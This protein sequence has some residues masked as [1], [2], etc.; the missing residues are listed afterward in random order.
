M[1]LLGIR[2]YQRWGTCVVCIGLSALFFACSSS[3]G[4]NKPLNEAESIIYLHG[5]IIAKALVLFATDNEEIYP[6][7][8]DELVPGYL[9]TNIHV[10]K[11]EL[12]T[13]RSPLRDGDILI[14]GEKKRNGRR[15]LIRGDMQVYFL[16][17][18]N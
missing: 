18:G 12:L 5:E 3:R 7:T 15:L 2:D 6:G 8:L 14:A 11:F 16:D 4:R 1:A 13:P 17:A 9:G 10:G